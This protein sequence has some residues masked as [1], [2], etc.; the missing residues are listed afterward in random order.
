MNNQPCILIT[1]GAGFIGSVLAGY[2]GKQGYTDI[3][4]V[5]HFNNPLKLLNLEGKPVTQKIESENLFETLRTGS[6]QPD[7]IFHLGARIDT[8][9]SEYSEQENQNV[10][11]SQRLWAIASE[12]KVPFIYASSAATYGNDDDVADDEEKLHSLHPVGGYGKAKHDFDLWAVN[13]AVKPPLWAGLKFFNVYGPNEYH[14]GGRASM[15][16][17][18][19]KEAQNG[20]VVRLFGS[21]KPTIP[22]GGHLRDFIY[23]VDVAKVCTWFLNQWESG[24]AG[25]LSGIYNVGT[26]QPRTYNDLAYTVFNRLGMPPSIQ[27]EPIPEAMRR[28]YKDVICAGIGKLRNAGYYEPMYSLEEG[29]KDYVDHFLM[30]EAFY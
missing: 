20:G 1:G 23:V 8:L 30:K 6:V 15:V 4:V 17:R 25:R 26:A 5:D 16:Y 12:K 29:I 22:D 21:N 19:F 10:T 18:C 28:D 7:F 11:F 3:V 9:K 2:L 24:N 13:Q 27:Y 14:K